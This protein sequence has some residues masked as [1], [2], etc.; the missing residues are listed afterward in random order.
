MKLQARACFFVTI[1]WN[2]KKGSESFM[3][4]QNQAGGAYFGSPRFRQ[5][6]PTQLLTPER[7]ED[8]SVGKAVICK[9]GD[10]VVLAGCLKKVGDIHCAVSAESV[11]I[12]LA[13]SS[14]SNDF[15][16]S[17]RPPSQ[18]VGDPF[19]I[20]VSKECVFLA[21]TEEVLSHIKADEVSAILQRE[22]HVLFTRPPSIIG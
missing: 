11:V 8:G 16:N 21:G 6:I 9:Q 13:Q 22:V 17:P 14:F 10:D 19:W 5:E 3:S 4:R 1:L 20:S 18:P 7:L 2:S 15:Y 12:K